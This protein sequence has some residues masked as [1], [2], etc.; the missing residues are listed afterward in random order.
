M[1]DA[2]VS[3]GENTNS[4]IRN[5]VGKVLAYLKTFVIAKRKIIIPIF[6]FLALI[7]TLLTFRSLKKNNIITSSEKWDKL[8]IDQKYTPAYILSPSK[9]SK[10]G[11]S[12]KETFLL[13]TKD[14]QDENTVRENL[15]SSNPVKITKVDD[16]TF[17]VDSLNNIGIG[18]TL[19]F[20]M[21]NEKDYNWIFQTAPKFKI[22]Q[23]LPQNE[24]KSV[25]INAGVEF[26][27]NNDNYDLKNSDI[28]IQPKVD[29]RIEK[30]DERASIVPLKPL[31]PKTI[32][33]VKIKKSFSLFS[34][35]NSL[36]EDYNFSFQT[37]DENENKG[38]ISLA[39]DFQEIFPDEH[40]ITKVH[41]DTFDPNQTIN[42]EVYKFPSVDK[43]ISSRSNLDKTN[44]S[45]TQYYGEENMIDTKSLA[46]VV[47]A[48]LKLQQKDNLQYL[49]L[50]QNLDEGMYLIQFWFDNYKKVEQLWVQ[51]SSVAGYVSVGKIQTVVWLNSSKNESVASSTVSVV[52]AGNTYPTNNEGWAT[53]PTPTILFDDKLKHYLLVENTSGKE[54]VL[55]VDNLSNNKKPDD[56]VS[57]DYW[58]YIYNERVLYK[59]NDSVYFWGVAKDRDTG[60]PPSTVDIYL[61]DDLKQS[62]TPQS[63][64][65]FIG[66]INLIDESIG[67]KTLFSK[68]NGVVLDSSYFQVSEYVKPELKIEVEG[69]KKAIY[70]GESVDYKAKVTFFDGTPASNVNL[71]ISTQY[72]YGE[73]DKTQAVANDKGEI[74][75]KYQSK[76]DKPNSY[77]RYEGV[78][79]SAIKS[80]DGPSDGSA[81]VYVYG[82][83]LQINT[84]SSQ[85][86]NQAMLGATVN[87]LDLSLINDKGLSD[88]VS[89]VAANQKISLTTTKTWWEQ[90]QSGTYYDFVEKVTRPSYTYTQHDDV[91][92]K[93]DL[94]TDA[95]GKL[96][97]NLNLELNNSYQVKLS[98]ADSQGNI[99]ENTGYFYY[100]QYQDSSDKSPKAYLNLDRD[101]NE[102]SIGDEVDI[103]IQKSGKDYEKTTNNKFLFILANRGKQD[104]L[105]YENPELRFNF[106][107]KDIPEIYVGSIIFNGRYYEEVTTN[108]KSGWSC[109]GYDFYNNAYFFDPLLI[110]YQKEDSKLDVSI[111]TDKTKYQ[112]GEKAIVTV[113]V[114]KSGNPVDNASV[115]LT[116]VDEALAAIGGVKE[117]DILPSLYKQV[118]DLIYYNYYSHKPALPDGPQAERGGGGG[119]RDLF[120]DTA[121]FDTNRTDSSGTATFTV[122]LPDNIT[123]WLTYAQVVTNNVDAGQAKSSIIATKDFFVT[124]QFPNTITTKDSPLV[125][126]SAF[127]NTLKE[128]S[129]VPTNIVFNN[130]DQEVAKSSAVI[131]AFKESYV[132]FPKLNIG[133]YKVDVKGTYQNYEDGIALPVKVIGSRLD[134][135]TTTNKVLQKDEILKS[136]DNVHPEPSKSIKLVVT[137]EGKGKYYYDLLN[138]C[139]QGSNRIEK[140]VASMQA[141]KILTSRFKDATCSG[142][143]SDLANF[144]SSDGGLKQVE[145]GGSDLETTLWTVYTNPT[146]F[147]KEKLISYFENYNS[148]STEDKM[149][150]NWGLTLL[151]IPKVN[152]LNQLAQSATT[153]REKVVA[154][155]ALY[156]AGNTERSKEMYM[157]ILSEYGYT[158]KPY[159]RIQAD[160]AKADYD[161]YALDTSYALLLGTTNNIDGYNNGF[162][163]YLE[164]YSGRVSTVILDIAN[165]SYIDKVISNLPDKD[166]TISFTTSSQNLTKNITKNGFLNLNLRPNEVNDFNLHVIDG[167]ADAVLSYYL[168]PEEFS[169]LQSDNRISL[170]KTVTKVKGDTGNSIKIGDILRVDLK[171]GFDSKAPL[172]CYTLTDQIPSGMTYLENP[173][174]YDLTIGQRGTLYLEKANI[175]KGCASNSEWW[176]NYTNN[177]STYFVRVTGAGKFVQEP[178]IIQSSIDNSIFQKT[179]EEYITVSK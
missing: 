88:P 2:S 55:P 77:P 34:S 54:L 146:P 166:T 159:L 121:F 20:S 115:Q 161:T 86:K 63:D 52:G 6:I 164:N 74:T 92:D 3:S 67:Y 151:G 64:G 150:Q 91:I 75:F 5:K 109:G 71:Y 157:E 105:V 1:D 125:A 165:I 78:N 100:S 126:V 131:N 94:Y 42:A 170:T 153:Y 31:Q 96:I 87:K 93:K 45:W 140:R 35:N 53:F 117:P 149:L 113:K 21:K 72:G 142:F 178:A 123:N 16:N 143:N 26:T 29:F 104:V 98:V 41:A 136:F 10:Y 44:S 141:D 62:V 148:Y 73:T 112:P 158:N 8:V 85:N 47:K 57:D 99:V 174:N 135:N 127:G 167:K 114:T 59:P 160:P 163:I 89:G 133:D 106:E 27:F 51:S 90:K 49:E 130:N 139:Y 56:T 171:Y 76:F 7:I 18:E 13:K 132:E 101:S 95:N 39:K 23:T 38:R 137:D 50:P 12:S 129:Q 48:D 107:Q 46:Q 179:S 58:S 22:T 84:T 138:Y 177:I 128:N 61:G 25:P 116:A 154:A 119:S 124:S 43:F 108:C 144:Q 156:S 19:S 118:S 68:V 32:Y 172:G 111:I 15:T 168:T 155:L 173:D 162:N 80:G 147:D 24:A 9:S 82:S 97:Y 36:S 28:E 60:L 14:P 30:H 176:K 169:K 102:F 145:W 33:S 175:V 40:L 103:K 70:A 81:S 17:K 66:K 122:N 65:S 83:R 79:I 37:S 120:K 11:I 69:N 152:E 4:N 134:F 110:K